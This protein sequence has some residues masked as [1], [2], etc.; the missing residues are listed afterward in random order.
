[1]ANRDEARRGIAIS[2]AME[3]ILPD[4]GKQFR[5]TVG[6]GHFSGE[7]AIGITGA[8]RIDD[9]TALYFGIGTDIDGEEVGGKVGVSVQW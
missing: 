7:N 8:G 3:V 5:V 6:G 9:Q 4:P 1:V 2:N